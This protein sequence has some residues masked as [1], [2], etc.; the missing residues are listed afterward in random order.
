[1]QGSG[2]V[3]LRAAPDEVELVVVAVVFF[4]Q[5]SHVQIV[6][7]L[8]SQEQQKQSICF[9]D[10]LVFGAKGKIMYAKSDD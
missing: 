2:A 10:R 5:S 9:T 7:L 4:R 6:T 1:M 3:L 8:T